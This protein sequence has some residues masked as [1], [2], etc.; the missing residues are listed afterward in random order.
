MS[1]LPLEKKNNLYVIP[2]GNSS[3]QDQMEL[4]IKLA[5]TEEKLFALQIRLEN[6]DYK[7]TML[8]REIEDLKKINQKLKNAYDNAINVFKYFKLPFPNK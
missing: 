6:L 1:A 8:E 4:L 7:K 2:G 3:K 5:E